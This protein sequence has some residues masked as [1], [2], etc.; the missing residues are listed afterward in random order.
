MWNEVWW[1]LL[2]LA[3]NVKRYQAKLSKIGWIYETRWGK[4]GWRYEVKKAKNRPA[5]DLPSEAALVFVSTT[6]FKIIFYWIPE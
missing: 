4:I 2:K 1:G 6:D 5:R 3:D